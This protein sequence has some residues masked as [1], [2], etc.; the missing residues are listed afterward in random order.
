MNKDLHENED[1]IKEF[2]YKMKLLSGGETR[3]TVSNCS[4]YEVTELSEPVEQLE[5]H[6][7][8]LE[9]DVTS[10]D[11]IQSPSTPK[12]QRNKKKKKLQ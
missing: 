10:D 12:E 1:L 11:N 3:K 8:S 2:T 5:D 7:Y 4:E 6:N 9:V